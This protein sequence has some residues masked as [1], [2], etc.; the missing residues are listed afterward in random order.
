MLDLIEP[1][2]CWQN[3]RNDIE[4][5]VQSEQ[6]FLLLSERC[7]SEELKRKHHAPGTYIEPPSQVNELWYMV[8]TDNNQQ[9]FVGV[10]LQSDLRKYDIEHMPITPLYPESNRLCESVIGTL[11][12][13]ILETTKDSGIDKI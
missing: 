5:F 2:F 7:Q 3:L 10:N 12:G 6:M 13:K 1:R 11:K 9:S 4:T 8:I